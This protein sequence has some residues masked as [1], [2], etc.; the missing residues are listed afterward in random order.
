[1]LKRFI[2]HYLRFFRDPYPQRVV[3]N[4]NLSKWTDVLSGIPQG[5]ILGSI[6]FILYINDLPGVVGS[7]CKLFADDFNYIV[8]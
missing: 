8:I 3:I 5:S 6:L 1:M 4:G 7:V 2:S